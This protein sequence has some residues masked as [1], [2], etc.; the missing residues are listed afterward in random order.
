MDGVGHLAS[1][2]PELPDTKSS[3]PGTLGLLCGRFPLMKVEAR[4]LKAKAL[5]SLTLGV[6]HFTRSW[7]VGRVDAVLMLLDHSFEMLLKAAILHRGGK[8]RH[9]G[10]KNTH[11]F[12]TCVRIALSTEGIKFLSEE[13]ALILQTINGLRDAAQHHLVTVSEGHLY[14][15]AQAGITLFRDLLRDVFGEE[16]RDY[17]PERTLAMSTT[18]QLE[19]IALFTEE[20]DQVARL[21]K[22][23]LHRRAEATARLRA[24]AVMDGAIRGEKV[25]PGERELKKLGE[26]V[27]AGR[28]FAE[29]FPGISSVNFVR[30]EIGVHINLRKLHDIEAVGA[31][32]VPLHLIGDRF[33]ECTNGTDTSFRVTDLVVLTKN[34]RRLLDRVGFVLG[35]RN[36]LAVVGPS[37]AGKSTLLGALTGFR[38]ADTGTVDYAGCNLYH[39]YDELRCRIGLVPQEDILHPQLTVRTALRYAARLRFPAEATAAERERRIDEVLAQLGLDATVAAQRISTLSG[40]Q[41]KR[42]SLALELLTRPSL[43]FLDEPTTGLDP[44]HRK[45]VMQRLR[46]LAD[47]GRTVVTVTHD[48][49]SLDICDRLLVLARGGRLAYFGP[50]SEALR[51]FGQKD[52]P[53]LFLLLDREEH[54]D[55]SARFASSPEAARY[56]APPRPPRQP[57]ARIPTAR[58]RQRSSSSQF[59]VLCRRNLS[60]IGADRQYTAFLLAMPL[61]LSMFAHILP[62]EAGLSWMRK[63]ASPMSPGAPQ[64]LLLVLIVSGAFAGFAAAFRELVKERAIYRRE[65]AFGL[66]RGAYLGS[67]LVVLGGIAALQGLVVGMLGTAGKPGPDDSVLLWSGRAE[68]VLALVAVTIAMMALGLLVSA[69]IGNADRGMPLLVVA[70]M[71]Q[72]VLCGGLFP[73]HDR[74]LLAELSWLVPARWAFAMGAATGQYPPSG[75]PPPPAPAPVQF[76][77][78]WKHT[79]ETWVVDLVALTALTVLFVLATAVALR[80]LEPRRG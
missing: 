78:L 14:L 44:G 16:L 27:A 28:S 33:S 45:E 36:L 66:S 50:P 35:E 62:G 12:D 54:T 73:L 15:Q 17:L 76:D 57:P 52:F 5:S 20:V 49:N 1:G 18:A 32:H 4:L 19:P 23:G 24:L 72:L 34:G 10:A 2:P 38:P 30:E 37:G 70:L 41:R 47:E 67:K 64:Q 31:G 25:Q 75:T 59:R 6:D 11:G 80:R 3:S 51:Y 7:D 77:P 71:L 79:A 74:Q 60:V 40:G 29:V 42:T 68:V 22:P 56:L 63:A 9:R 8:I 13:Q 21:L 53:D 65:Q 55:W 46:E 48:E 69:V 43:L 58:P 39:T 61:V 26:Q